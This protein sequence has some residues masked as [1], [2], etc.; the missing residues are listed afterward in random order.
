MSSPAKALRIT[1]MTFAMTG[2][3]G[4]VLSGNRASADVRGDVE[5]KLVDTQKRAAPDLV[6][7]KARCAAA[8][9]KPAGKVAAGVYRCTVAVEGVAV[10]YDVTVRTGGVVKTGTF[11]M[12]NAK[13]VIDTKKLIAIAASVVDDP[14]KAK[15][16]CGKARV[17]VA[18]PGTTLACTVVD[19]SATQILTFAV[20]DLRGVVSLVN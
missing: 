15:I 18:A 20:K 8:L 2:L 7:G 9:A 11:T 17:V 5:A 6:V 12:Q 4:G 14:K 10:P 16:S 19:G 3:W 1:V 13:A